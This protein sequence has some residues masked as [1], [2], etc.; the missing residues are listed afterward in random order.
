MTT[1]PKSMLLGSIGAIV[2]GMLFKFRALPFLKAETILS[3]GKQVPTA[4]FASF[5][6]NGFFIFGFGTF[7]VAI[8][9]LAFQKKRR[10]S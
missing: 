8:A 10:N 1:T 3:G 6:A 2:L 4:D 7:V 5:M 9:Y